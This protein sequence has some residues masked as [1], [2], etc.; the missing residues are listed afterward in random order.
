MEANLPLISV[1]LCT[2]N[3][4]KYLAQQLDSILIQTYT[5]L[6]ILISDDV[7]TDKTLEILK[8]YNKKDK[9]IRICQNSHNLGFNKNFEKAVSLAGA[10]WIAI[11][12]QDDIWLP[13]KLMALY[14]SV[15]PDTLL[16]H[17]YNAEFKNDDPSKIFTNRSRIRFVGNKTRQLIFYNTISGHTMLFHKKLL[18][19]SLPFQDGVYYDWWMG[20]QASL[21]SNIQLHDEALVLHRQHESNFS[22]V[23][24]TISLEESKAVFFRQRLHTLQCFRQIKNLTKEDKDLL[25][26]YTK[27]LEKE[28]KKSFSLRVFFFF[29]KH[30]RSAFYYRKKKFMFF[31]YLKYSL[32]KATM[33][34]ENWT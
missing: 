22:H 30:S 29:L 16:I 2:Y 18:S 17:S 13:H 9:R 5:N 7:S 32:K 3:G 11:A 33:K 8:A 27:I 24:K 21:Q 1:V 4:E 6:E 14:K 31:Y 19:S 28:S 23:N 25:T 12:D 10:D 20:I 26:E 34:V 15:A